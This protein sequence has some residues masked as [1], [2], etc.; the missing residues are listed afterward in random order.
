MIIVANPGIVNAGP[1]EFVKSL[2]VLYHNAQSF[3]I[4]QDAGK[5]NPT[6]QTTKVLE[7]QSYLYINMPDVVVLNAT[8]LSKS[9]LDEEI[10]PNS[11]YK[12]FRR[13]RTTSSHPFDKEYPKKFRKGD[14][15]VA[16]AIRSDL[17]VTSTVFKSNAKAEVLSI[18][19]KTSGGKN[20]CISTIYRVGT[21]GAENL[22]EIS[23]HLENLVGSKKLHK[24][25][26][27][28]DLNLNQVSWPDGDT[29]CE[30]QRNFVNLFL[31][32][33]FE[34]LINKPT[35]YLGNTLDIFYNQNSLS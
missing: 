7:F 22:S 28:G 5:P 14:G 30:L 16:I 19:L 10:F 13:D 15:G 26:I 9:I 3:I 6:L 18:I 35:H 24:H 29:T 8:W 33:G 32:K 1:A 23:K 27:V 21:L 4:P 17:A 2:S 20:F 12:V 31:D 11:N 25:I 34:Q